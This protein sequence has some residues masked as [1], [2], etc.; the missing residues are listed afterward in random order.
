MSVRGGAQNPADSAPA[1]FG[2]GRGQVWAYDIGSSTLHLVYESPAAATL[3]LPDNVVV[4]RSGT[5]ILC[6]DGSGD[7]FLRGL[8]P[9]G[10]I[11]DF[12]RNADPGPGRPGIRRRH[13]LAGLQGGRPEYARNPTLNSSTSSTLAKNTCST[14]SGD[15][16]ARQ[17]IVC[18]APA[19]LR[20]F[21][22]WRRSTNGVRNL[23]CVETRS[24][25]VF[26]TDPMA[27]FSRIPVA[28][29]QG[30][31]LDAAGRVSGRR[32]SVGFF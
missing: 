8:T 15:P 22:G 25:C 2:D 17:T 5:M 6:E 24:S 23:I 26:D 16:Y 14:V 1:G 27:S 4:S 28:T 19:R 18:G 9:G 30:L 3:D 32:T 12:A 29:A 10:Q 20:R 7:N 11:L 13:V 21:V 31:F